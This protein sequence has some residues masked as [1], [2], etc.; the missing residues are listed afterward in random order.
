ME[1]TNRAQAEAR[2]KLKLAVERKVAG[3]KLANQSGPK[4]DRLAYTIRD[5]VEM[6]L[7]C[8]ATLHNLIRVA[9]R[10]GPR[11]QR[12]HLVRTRDLVPGAR[13][14]CS[15]IDSSWEGCRD[16]F[17][18]PSPPHSSTD[19]AQSCSYSCLPDRRL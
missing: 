8:K 11:L 3:R 15:Q 17:S 9:S 18:L 10:L 1:A 13:I 16:L 5:L 6:G 14:S 7:G 2:R 12:K 19:A 4:L